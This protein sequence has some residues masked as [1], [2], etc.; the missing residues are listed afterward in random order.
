MLSTGMGLAFPAVSL[1]ALTNQ[2]EGMGLTDSEFS[3]FGE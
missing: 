2:T 3:W 1:T